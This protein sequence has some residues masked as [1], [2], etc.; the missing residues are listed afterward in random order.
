[1]RIENAWRPSGSTGH[2]FGVYEPSILEVPQSG[3]TQGLQILVGESPTI[4]A[5]EFSFSRFSKL[6]AVIAIASAATFMS[7]HAMATAIVRE[8]LPVPSGVG[9]TFF[10]PSLARD[11][12]TLSSELRSLV[13]A[14]EC[15]PV[16]DGVVHPAEQHVAEFLR[17]HGGQVLCDVIFG[18]TPTDDFTASVL[19]LLGRTDGINARLQSDL[20]KAGLTSRSVEVRDAAIQAAEL[21]D[22]SALVEVLRSHTEAIP[23]IAAYRDQVVRDIGESR[24]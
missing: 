3:S 21:W 2:T 18:A 5:S 12:Q 23:W 14:V 10:N 8:R 16:E 19:R 11:A 20:V 9:E 1:M 7:N 4:G 22:N 6:G 17:R 13:D 15:E 24:A